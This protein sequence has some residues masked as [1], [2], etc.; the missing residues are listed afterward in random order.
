MKL[1]WKFQRGGAGYKPNNSVFG[2]DEIFG[3]SLN[4][5]L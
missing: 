2:G 4:N 3:F 1:N 5:E